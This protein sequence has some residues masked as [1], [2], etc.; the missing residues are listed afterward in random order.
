MPVIANGGL[1]PVSGEAR[2]QA[3]LCDAVAFGRAWIANPDLVERIA[4]GAALNAPDMAT[5]YAG[6]DKGYLDYPTLAA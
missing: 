3:G 4:R 6:G 1:D 5:F 2:L